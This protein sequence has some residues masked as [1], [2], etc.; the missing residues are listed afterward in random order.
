MRWHEITE[1]EV[2]T[3]INMPEYVEHSLEGRLNVWRKTSSKYIR[4]TY[5]EEAD[6]ILVITAVKKKKGW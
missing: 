2:E 3:T 1:F 4:V 6:K 5:K